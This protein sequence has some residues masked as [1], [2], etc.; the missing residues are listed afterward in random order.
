MVLISLCLLL[1]TGIAMAQDALKVT[2]HEYIARG[3]TVMLGR[4]TVSGSNIQEQGFCWSTS[5]EP[6]IDDNR[7]TKY[8]SHNG[9]IYV[10]ENLFVGILI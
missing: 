4:S 1:G 9:R 5:P 10:M 6:T 8:H 7:S 2:T 3:S